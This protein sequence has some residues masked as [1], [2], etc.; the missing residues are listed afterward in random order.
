[1]GG[2]RKWV[3]GDGVVHARRKRRKGW[4]SASQQVAKRRQPQC[5]DLENEHCSTSVLPQYLPLETGRTA[6]K[7]SHSVELTKG[8][9]LTLKEGSGWCH[10]RTSPLS[11]ST[12]GVGGGPSY[13]SKADGHWHVEW[14]AHYCKTCSRMGH[15][16]HSSFPCFFFRFASEGRRQCRRMA[17]EGCA[18]TAARI[19]PTSSQLLNQCARA[20]YHTPLLAGDHNAFHHTRCPLII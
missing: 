2:G 16:C 1:M 11:S 7:F 13:G 10:A 15:C 20:A 19:V 5:G 9:V 4:E 3:G 17:E 18:S 6:S 8:P 12:A 14:T